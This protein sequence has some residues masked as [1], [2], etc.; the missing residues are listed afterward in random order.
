MNS[1]RQ[2][3]AKAAAYFARADAAGREL[4]PEERQEVQSWLDAAEQQKAIEHSIKQ[5][6]PGNGL[7]EYV[8]TG[9]EDHPSGG[10]G[11]AFV[12]AEGY[13]RISD[14]ARRGQSFSSGRD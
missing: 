4:T 2:L 9:A 1:S 13:K 8:V 14:P 3:A 10:W 5:L 11:D 7:S 12:K 6:D